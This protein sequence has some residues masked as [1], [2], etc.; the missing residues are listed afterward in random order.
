MALPSWMVGILMIALLAATLS[1]TSILIL[2][3]SHIIVHD[4]F[5]KV[6]NPGM[7][8]KAFLVITRITILVC[9][10]LVILPALREPKI[11]P[12]LMWIFSFA[13]PV[14]GVYLI[15]MMW[16]INKTAAWVTILA[17]YVADFLWTIVPPFGLPEDLYSNV[18]PT[19]VVTIVFGNITGCD[20]MTP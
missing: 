9:M 20:G 3:S 15:G 1:T 10:G 5:K 12:L 4:I 13:I 17:G 11:L 7:S 2:S 16:K 19:T 14:F 6:V 18:Y 8:D